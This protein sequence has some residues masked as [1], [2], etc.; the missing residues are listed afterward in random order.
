MTVA[1]VLLAACAGKSTRGS[2]A[3]KTPPATSA[4]P[5][6]QTD[7][8]VAA[9]EQ[10]ARAAYAGYVQTWAIASQAADPDN[11]DLARYVADPLLSLTR[12]NIQKLKDIGAVQLGA[13][14]ST[15]IATR[16]D[17]AAKPPTVTITA[18]LDYSALK[19]VYRSNQ[20]PVP[21]SA[22]TNPKVP[23]VATV[24]L[25]ATGQWLVNES[26]QGTHTC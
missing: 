13:Q 23:S 2:P 12:N 20:S 8:S 9:A 17:L 15:V 4:S 1:V 16:V 24:W 19:L 7:P 18:C 26:K 22:I 21:N 14:R 25:Y 6:P 5:S 3:T 10:M 11:P